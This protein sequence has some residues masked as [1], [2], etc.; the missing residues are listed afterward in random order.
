MSIKA[1]MAD[2]HT[3]RDNLEAD[4]SALACMEAETASWRRQ[5]VWEST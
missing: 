1:A 2:T 4:L 3:G 5:L